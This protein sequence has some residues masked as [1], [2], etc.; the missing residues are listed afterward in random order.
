MDMSVGNYSVTLD[1]VR[2]DHSEGGYS[3]TSWRLPS[4]Y[5]RNGQPPELALWPA[6]G[7]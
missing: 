3:P 7:S 5:C 1:T 2:Y 6:G 4:S